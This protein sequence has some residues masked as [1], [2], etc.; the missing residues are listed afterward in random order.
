MVCSSCSIWPPVR[1][2]AEGDGQLPASRFAVSMKL[3]APGEYDTPRNESVTPPVESAQL[4][5]VN[6]SEPSVMSEQSSEPPTGAPSTT[7]MS[8]QLKPL[9]F[10]T[11]QSSSL[12]AK[13]QRPVPPPGADLLR[14]HLPRGGFG[15]VVGTAHE[16]GELL[17]I[18]TIFLLVGRWRRASAIRDQEEHDRVVNEE[19]E[20]LS[21]SDQFIEGVPA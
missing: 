12:F 14:S 8:V 7:S 13:V 10:L 1:Q 5:C 17:F 19:F 2:F 3:C 20:E 16:F 15:P 9:K 18:P 6:K 4:V 21:T 11:V